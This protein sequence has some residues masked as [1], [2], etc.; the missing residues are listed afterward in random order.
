MYRH[1]ADAH[2]SKEE[3]RV[4]LEKLYAG[5]ITPDNT[6][7]PAPKT[8]RPAAATPLAVEPKA[9][10][11]LVR[12]T[13]PI[14]SPET[15]V[16]RPAPPALPKDEITAI[17]ARSA[18]SIANMLASKDKAANQDAPQEQELRSPFTGQ[19]LKQCWDKLSE[20][21]AAQKRVGLY[22]SMNAADVSPGENFTVEIAVSSSAAAHELE[23]NML[24][25]LAYL[26]KHLRNTVIS[27]RI[28]VHEGIR[29]RLPYTPREK[30]EYLRQKNPLIE[31]MRNEL[32]LNIDF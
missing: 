8:E 14:I 25:I 20:E 30:Y 4:F 23:G 32:D 18:L 12:E 21:Y 19:E 22:T 6:L 16:H 7:R 15:T 26:K 13:P 24:E 29:E 31:K 17:K 1:F 28:T 5:Q 3:I 27:H 9:P 2:P 11:A 10:D